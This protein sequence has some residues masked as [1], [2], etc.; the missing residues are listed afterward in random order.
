MGDKRDKGIRRGEVWR[1]EPARGKG[2]RTEPQGF[3]WKRQRDEPM[4]HYRRFQ[5][6][7]KLGPERSVRKAAEVTKLLPKARLPAWQYWKQIAATWHWSD[8]A[9]AFDIWQDEIRQAEQDR[10]AAEAAIR[11]A[12][13]NEEQRQHRVNAARAVNAAVRQVLSRFLKDVESLDAMPASK[14]VYALNVLALAAKN[15]QYI[16]L[17]EAGKATEITKTQ[18]DVRRMT[19]D[20]VELIREYVPQEKWAEVIDRMAGSREA[21]I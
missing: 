8:R 12:E 21:N 10:L 16:E 20:L 14:I 4:R 15:S 9:K 6:Y 2:D 17:L 1:G 11:Q 5:Q 13:E 7:L 19:E 18:T 3:P